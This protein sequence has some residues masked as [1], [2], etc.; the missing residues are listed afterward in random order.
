MSW[1][2]FRNLFPFLPDDSY[3]PC[4]YVS[5]EGSRKMAGERKPII[6]PQTQAYKGTPFNYSLG[7]D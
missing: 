7:F 6:T 1:N 3:G 2:P 4:T 5:M